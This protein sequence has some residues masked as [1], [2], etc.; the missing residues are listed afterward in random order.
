MDFYRRHR[1]RRLLF[2]FCRILQHPT[3]F[4]EIALFYNPLTV[5]LKIPYAVG[6]AVRCVLRGESKATPRFLL[7]IF[8]PP[9]DF[10]IKG[11]KT[12]PNGSLS[13]QGLCLPDSGCILPH[14]A[15]QGQRRAVTL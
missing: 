4:F 13:L 3:I 6:V 10:G 2:L 7:L 14:G 5:F 9:A 11:A 8:V 15:A 1:N 12:V